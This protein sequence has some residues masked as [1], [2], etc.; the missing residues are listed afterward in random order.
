MA[1]Y[2][3]ILALLLLS[4]LAFC[5]PTQLDRFISASFE[6]DQ[7]VTTGQLAGGYT[8]ISADGVETYVVDQTGKSIKEMASLEAILT[9]D[10]KSS[11]GYDTKVSSALS[12]PGAV[13]DAKQ[14]DEAK[15]MQYLGLNMYNCTDKQSCIVACFAVPQ[16][17]LIINADGFVEAMMDYN[18]KRLQFDSL[19]SNYSSGLD[20]VKTDPS[21]I[22]Q[23]LSK[24]GEMGSVSSSIAVN[25]IFLNR[26]DPQCI[27]NHASTCFE[28]CP[29]ADYS[30]S[31]IEAQKQN[32]QGLKAVL[33]GIAAQPTRAAAI[34]AK[35]SENDLYLST[36]KENFSSFR[37]KMNGDIAGLK[38]KNTS[39]SLSVSD[40]D[41]GGMLVSLS[42]LSAS[43]DADA[44]AGYYRRA[45]ARRGEY[46]AAEKAVSDRMGSE[47]AA[48][49]N[50]TTEFASLEANINKSAWIIGNDSTALFTAQLAAIE[51][52]ASKPATVQQI[53]SARMAAASLGANLAQQAAAATQNPQ[54]VAG[55]AAG[56]AASQAKGSIP[57][58][59]AFAMLIALLFVGAR[60]P[61]RK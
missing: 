14:A 23:K 43:I 45:M 47:L 4:S 57:C 55:A 13:S 56:A 5:T 15:C 24:L 36:K 7:V 35:G 21:A 20:A 37:L 2:L 40:P 25:P 33:S 19:L 53:S 31:R 49:D 11:A 26:T 9:D 50:M 46:D 34:Q 48:Y 58:L 51:Q 32:L 29:K 12:F 52:N 59:P 61:R 60:T 39:F 42:N 41:V 18:S 1:K 44:Q 38:S 17:D 10:A 22:D 8:V 3:S 54:A 28:Y 27:G 30:A 16:C 6:P